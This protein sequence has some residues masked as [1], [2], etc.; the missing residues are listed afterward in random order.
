MDFVK[1]ELEIAL[2]DSLDRFLAD[3]YDFLIHRRDASGAHP[4]IWSALANDLGV[5]AA[6]FS[7]DQG[8]LGGGQAEIGVV[9][10]RF[11][12]HLVREPFLSTVVL[13]GGFLRRAGSPE[14]N[15]VLGDIIAGTATVA[16][17]FLEDDS[18]YDPAGVE[19]RA[20]SVGSD[21]VITGRK[22][23]VLD[24]AEAKWLIV[25]ARAGD[26]SVSAFLVDA[27][28]PAIERQDYRLLD[29]ASA[30][31]I[32][33]DAVRVPSSRV[34]GAPGAGL[35]LLEQVLDEAA[36]ASCAE[37]CGLMQSM[38]DQTVA[39]TKERKQF[40]RP[41]AD[42]QVLQH[43]MVDMLIAVKQATCLLAVARAKLDSPDRASAVSAA[44]GRIGQLCRYVA[45]SA[46]QLHGAIGIT[47]ETAISHY[48]RRG[49]M[50]ERMFGST[51]Y[52]LSRYEDRELPAD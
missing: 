39:Y 32:T 30:S 16:V 50:L 9:M 8:G 17:G 11:G 49:M 15:A 29:G 21:W 37:A 6:P 24:A 3:R 34:L 31:T 22:S 14:A 41:V 2:G 28:D 33:L 18:V 10:E 44:K 35:A 23:L 26:G 42:N 43:R 1:G 38:L 5:L 52:H 7:E 36:T 48:F 45:Q 20:E 27:A 4:D 46:V 40:G 12:R 25:T 13:G 19:T 47:D 51:D